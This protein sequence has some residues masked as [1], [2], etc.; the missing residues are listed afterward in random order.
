MPRISRQM[1]GQLDRRHEDKQNKEFDFEKLEKL[2]PEVYLTDFNGGVAK[3][4][5]SWQQTSENEK[6]TWIYEQCRKNS[7]ETISKLH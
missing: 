3:I 2:H 7:L 5:H 4:A 1:H 6:L